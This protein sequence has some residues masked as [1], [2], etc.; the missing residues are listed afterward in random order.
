MI[1]ESA[2]VYV[3]SESKIKS[4]VIVMSFRVID[5]EFS[6]KMKKSPV[7]VGPAFVVELVPVAVPELKPVLVK[8]PSSMMSG[9][10]V[11]GFE[12]VLASMAKSPV[13]FK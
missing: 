5:D 12:V 6:P 4:P 13:I 1:D 9:A 2:V 10:M 7:K 8:L 3:F 11:I